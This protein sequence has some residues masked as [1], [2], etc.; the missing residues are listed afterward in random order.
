MQARSPLRAALLDAVQLLI[1][2]ARQCEPCI[3]NA[4]QGDAGDLALRLELDRHVLTASCSSG[5]RAFH[6]ARTRRGSNSSGHV[7]MS[8]SRL[9]II[10]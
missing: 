5:K 9:R 3:G 6:S 2:G 10:T 7:A 1:T 4:G 8:R